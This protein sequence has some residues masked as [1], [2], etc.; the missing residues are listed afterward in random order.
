MAN[1]LKMAL[2]E[3]IITLHGHGWSRRRIARELGI[4]RET[5]GRYVGLGPKPASKAPTDSEAAGNAPLGIDPSKPANKA[6]TGPPS[7][8]A[9]WGAVIT[10]KLE[11]G[12]TAQRI[13]QDLVSEHGYAG[14]YYSVRRLIRKLGGAT[15]I[16]FRRMECEPGAEAQV[17]FGRGAP[18]VSTDGKRRGSWV[19]RIVLSRKC[20]AEHTFKVSGAV[21]NMPV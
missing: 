8:A 16:P 9:P 15:P 1:Q 20:S 6:P 17:D 14:S 10:A 2:V 11:A 3:S 4:H 13:Y 18:I 21:V 5:V 19:F 7:L 12:L